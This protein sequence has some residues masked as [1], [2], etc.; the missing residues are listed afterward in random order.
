MEQDTGAPREVERNSTSHILD[1]TSGQAMV[2]ARIM[3]GDA[4]NQ[5]SGYLTVVVKANR[6]VKAIFFPSVRKY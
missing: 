6:A 2:S 1:E 5:T 4:E 3:H